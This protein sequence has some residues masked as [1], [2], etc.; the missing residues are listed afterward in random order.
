MVVVL[1]RRCNFFK[2]GA[3]GNAH[4]CVEIGKGFV[5]KESG[6]LAD[7]CPANGDALALAAGEGFRFAIEQM[8]DFENLRSFTDA[9]KNLLLGHAAEFEAEGHVFVDAHV[10]VKSVILEDHG[11][12]AVFGRHVVDDFGADLE[13]AG[14]D[15]FQAGDHAQGGGLAASGRANENDEFLVSDSEVDSIYSFDAAGVDFGYLFEFDSCHCGSHSAKKVPRGTP[16]YSVKE[17]IAARE[18]RGE[19]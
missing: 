1:R 13:S 2:F 14:G 4:F 8:R 19:N 12:V 17:Y 18:G 5:E 16:I 11:D 10:G 6:G 3:G 7:N 9:F 15:L